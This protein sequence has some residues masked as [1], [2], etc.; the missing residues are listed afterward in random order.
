[1]KK[2][3]SFGISI[4]ASSIMVIIVILTLICFAGLSLS[5]ANADYQLSLKLAER[6]KSYYDATSTAYEHL[7][8]QKELSNGVENSFNEQIPINDNQMLELKALLLSDANS[9]N[10]EIKSFKIINIKQPDL[11]DSLSLLLK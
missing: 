10:Y 2:R 3:K 1:M 9:N 5:S 7:Q 6:T 11:D 8:K 4:G